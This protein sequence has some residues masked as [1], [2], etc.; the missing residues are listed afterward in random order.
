MNDQTPDG[1]RA[2]TPMPYDSGD[3]IREF[4]ADLATPP[5]FRCEHLRDGDRSARL[6]C[7]PQHALCEL[8]VVL[9][10]V[11]FPA[12]DVCNCCGGTLGDPFR[13]LMSFRPSE[14]FIGLAQLCQDCRP[15]RADVAGSGAPR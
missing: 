10:D 12:C 8:C 7:A 3:C 9:A 11:L 13:S 6:M 5:I 15:K 4:A 1:N 14:R 2:V